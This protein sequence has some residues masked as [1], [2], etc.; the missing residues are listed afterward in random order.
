MLGGGMTP[1]SEKKLDEVLA[2]LA[3]RAKASKKKGGK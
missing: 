3:K 2:D 1:T